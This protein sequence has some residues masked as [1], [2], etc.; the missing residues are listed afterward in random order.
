M[1]PSQIVSL[2]SFPDADN[3]IARRDHAGRIE[4]DFAPLFGSNSGLAA[5]AGAILQPNAGLGGATAVGGPALAAP[6]VAA[7]AGV[8]ATVARMFAAGNADRHASLRVGRR[9]RVVPG[10]RLR[11]LRL[12]QLCA[13]RSG[14]A[15]GTARVRTVR[16]LGRRRS[17]PVGDDLR[18]RRSRVRHHCRLALRYGCAGADRQPLVPCPGEQRRIRRSTPTGTV[19]AR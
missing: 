5:R 11:L 14:T 1:K 10:H 19:T 9:P 3:T 8:P 15:P 7:P 13:R 2:L 4:I 18:E 17:R 6:T 16:E 12:G